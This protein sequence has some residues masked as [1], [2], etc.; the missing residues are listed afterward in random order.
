MLNLNQARFE[1]VVTQA[2]C[3]GNGRCER[4]IDRAVEQIETNPYMTRAACA[5][6]H[7]RHLQGERH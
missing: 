4:A 1:A 7:G 6:D 3:A 5:R 2:K